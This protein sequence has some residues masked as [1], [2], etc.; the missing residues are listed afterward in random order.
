MGRWSRVLRRVLG[1]NNTSQKKYQVFVDDNYHHGDE[2]ER[3]L[4]GEFGR[5]DDAIAACQKITRDSLRHLC[6]PGITAAKL[7]GQWAL[8]GEDPW[9]SGADGPVPF[10]A[11]EYVAQDLL[12]KIVAERSGQ[13]GR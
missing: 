11:R 4:H 13:P 10:S 3:Y 6:E 12:E 9:I 2:N 7:G 8:F 1:P 5:L